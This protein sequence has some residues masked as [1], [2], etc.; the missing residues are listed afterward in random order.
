MLKHSKL[1][2]GLDH[3]TKENWCVVADNFTVAQDNTCDTQINPKMSKANGQFIIKACNNHYELAQALEYFYNIS[4]DLES[5]KS[6]GY[7][8]QA[9]AMARKALNQSK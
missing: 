6:K 9:Q 3:D 4:F 1:P 5:S 7:I 2:W 8:K